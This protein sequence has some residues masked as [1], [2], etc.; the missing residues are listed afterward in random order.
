[1]TTLNTF[2]QQLTRSNQTEI[3]YSI[4]L[5]LPYTLREAQQLVISE[6]ERRTD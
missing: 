2:F 1:M 5:Y 6:L 3:A 4:Y